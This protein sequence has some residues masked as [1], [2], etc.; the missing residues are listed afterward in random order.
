MHYSNPSQPMREAINGT[1]I[2]AATV[3]ET[4]MGRIVGRAYV[5]D[6][7]Q[8]EG[9]E[10]IPMRDCH[11][12]CVGAALAPE[13]LDRVLGVTPLDAI[14]RVASNF[15]RAPH[16]LHQ[17]DGKPIVDPKW[18]VPLPGIASRIGDAVSA[19]DVGLSLLAELS[20]GSDDDTNDGFGSGMRSK[21]EQGSE[22]SP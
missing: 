7:W 4:L 8:A 17:C 6:Q 18:A 15:R 11:G 12:I 2:R 9:K 1:G 5:A 14:H 13:V 22:Q 3:T 10:P 20:G 21:P 19:Q 16:N